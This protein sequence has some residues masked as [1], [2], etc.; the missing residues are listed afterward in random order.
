M[1]KNV[2]KKERSTPIAETSDC[3]TR[4]KYGSASGGRKFFS[5]IIAARIMK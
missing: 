1:V 5:R 2:K 3:S 4:I